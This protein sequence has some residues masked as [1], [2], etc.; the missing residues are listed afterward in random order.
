LTS[1]QSTHQSAVPS[2][3][4]AGLIQCTQIREECQIESFKWTRGINEAPQEP[5]LSL[6]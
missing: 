5:A 3:A 6:Q 2:Q 4:D 1:V